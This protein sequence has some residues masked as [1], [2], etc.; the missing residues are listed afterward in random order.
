MGGGKGK[1][2]LCLIKEPATMVLVSSYDFKKAVSWREVF[3]QYRYGC[4][5]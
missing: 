5:L 4:F 2:G 1:G 3:K